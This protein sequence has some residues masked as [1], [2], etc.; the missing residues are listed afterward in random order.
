MKMMYGLVIGGSLV[1]AAALAW[2][3]ASEVKFR[4]WVETQGLVVDMLVYAE[5]SPKIA[6]EYQDEQLVTHTIYATVSYGNDLLDDYE[7]RENRVDVKYNPENSAEGIMDAFM[8]K[9]FFTVIFFPIGFIFALTGYIIL[10]TS[11]N[12]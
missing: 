4:S 7:K 9:H 1:M 2:S 11:K 10:V 5:N 12:R 8:Q 3:I 6:I